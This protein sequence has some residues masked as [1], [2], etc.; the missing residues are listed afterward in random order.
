MLAIQRAEQMGVQPVFDYQ[1]T[2][3][4]KLHE[5]FDVVYDTVGGGTIDASFIAWFR[6]PPP[7]AFD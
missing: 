5:R 7:A 2:D 1:T 6:D 3:L 4:T